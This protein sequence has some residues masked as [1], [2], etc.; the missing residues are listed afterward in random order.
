MFGREFLD[1]NTVFEFSNW[2]HDR[3]SVRQRKEKNEAYWT[4]KLNVQL[5]R[6]FNCTVQ[7]PAVFLDAVVDDEDDDEVAKFNEHL[8][9]LQNHLM[10]MPPYS[11][12]DI[13][14]W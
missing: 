2:A 12:K 4:H 5:R 10:T 7:V 8:S 3:K 1:N 13:E 14:C 11:C 6:L 9:K